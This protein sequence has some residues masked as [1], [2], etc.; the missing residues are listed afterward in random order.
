MPFDLDLFRDNFDFQFKV[1]VSNNIRIATKAFEEFWKMNAQFLS[2]ADELYGRILSYSVNRQFKKYAPLTAE[3]FLVSGKEV[4]SYKAKAIY[5]D[6][7]DYVTNVC[8]TD[9]PSKL[10]C[11]AN[12][13]LRLAQGNR[14]S[15]VQLEMFERRTD[16]EVIAGTPKKYAI[17]GYKY[18]RGE[19]Q[20]MNLM[21]PDSEFKSILY[22]ESLLDNI[23]EYYTYVPEDVVEETVASLKNDIA[24]E[25]EKREIV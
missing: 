1:R 15:D 23:K 9:S 18:I 8:R 2:D 10:P 24:K 16:R 3:T 7:P 12:Y 13:K 20:H 22:N 5:L 21:V 19:L 4:N 6:T 25:I 11:K 14:E 17:L